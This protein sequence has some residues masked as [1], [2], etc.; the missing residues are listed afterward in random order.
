M[1]PE[2]EFQLNTTDCI[3]K[4][5]VRVYK[6]KYQLNLLPKCAE[7]ITVDPEDPG[8]KIFHNEGTSLMDLC[9]NSDEIEI[10]AN[11]NL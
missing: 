11:V 5:K 6:I 4:E 8:K 2:E 7:Y 10:F 9:C 3:D 1:F